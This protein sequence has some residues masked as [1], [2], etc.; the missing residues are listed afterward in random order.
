MEGIWAI[1]LNQSCNRPFSMHSGGWTPAKSLTMKLRNEIVLITD[2]SLL[3]FLHQIF[4]AVGKHCA[5]DF[6]GVAKF[7]QELYLSIFCNEPASVKLPVAA[8]CIFNHGV[9]LVFTGDVIFVF[10][11]ENFDVLKLKIVSAI[12]DGGKKLPQ[13]LRP[14]VADRKADRPEIGKF[15]STIVRE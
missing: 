11:R 3:I 9:H 10:T 15:N 14:L 7:P 13:S 5:C 2:C 6:H 12:H 8:A 4:H 1:F